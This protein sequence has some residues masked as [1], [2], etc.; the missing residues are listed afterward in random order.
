MTLFAFDVTDAVNR[1]RTREAALKISA[2]VMS[3][4]SLDETLHVVLDNLAFIAG[5]NASALFL[6]EDDQWVGKAGYGE[7]TDEQIRRYRFPYEDVPVGVGGMALVFPDKR[8][9]TK[10][11]VETIFSIAN[12]LAVAI[13]SCAPPPYSGPDVLEAER[14]GVDAELP[15]VEGKLPGVKTEQPAKPRL[16]D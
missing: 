4:L 13:H 7:Y 3:S 14:S 11:T 16:Q 8:P 5:A 6:L 2:A 1:T 9:F 10:A 15:S 12:Q